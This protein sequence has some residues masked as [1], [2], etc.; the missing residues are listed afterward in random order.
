[1]TEIWQQEAIINWSQIILNSYQ[2]LLRKDLIERT[3][4]KLNQAKNLFYAPVIV[5]SHNTDSDPL[6]NYGNELGLKLWEMNWQ[7][8]ITT[9]SRT[10]TQPLEREERAR[11]LAKTT[12]QG[13]ITDYQGIRI[14]KRGTK[15]Q[16][17]NVTVWNL[18]DDDGQ[19]CGQAAT[20][21]QWK[22]ID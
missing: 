20:F 4:D 9:P 17:E 19:Y 8:L 7:E 15:Y 5:Y 16:I 10:T 13:Y 18:T 14:S 6:Y 11:L 2:K 1:M 3:G 22:V 21:S 12:S